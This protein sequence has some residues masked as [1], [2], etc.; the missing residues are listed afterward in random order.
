VAKKKS[1]AA[2]S[3]DP[4]ATLYPNIAAWVP[5]GVVEMG[6]DDM[7]RSFIR[8]LNYGNLIWEGDDFPTVH[9]ALQAA[10]RGIAAW[11]AENG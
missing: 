7:L 2:K 5:D 3:P 6:R 9:A 1:P 8:V 11:V 10:D 4:F